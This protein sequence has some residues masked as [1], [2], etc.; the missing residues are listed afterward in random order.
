AASAAASAGPRRLRGPLRLLVVAALVGAFAGALAAGIVVTF[1]D[2]ADADLPSSVETAAAPPP[3]PAGSTSDATEASA[4]AAAGTAGTSSAGGGVGGTNSADADS[5]GTAGTDDAAPT[6]DRAVHIDAKAIYDGIVASVVQIEV[7]SADNLLTSSR[8]TGFVLT[9]DG[10]I[11]TNAH[12]LTAGGTLDVAPP[13]APADP[14]DPDAEPPV[15][16]GDDV[17]ISVR[18][19]DG[20]TLEATVLGIDTSLDLAVIAVDATGLVPVKLGSSTGV[21]VGDEVMA[22]GNALG[23]GNTHTA[24]VGIVSAVERSV[25]LANT[26]LGRLIQ[27][28]AAVNPGNSGG[29]LVNAAGEVIGI[30]TAIAG[31]DYDGL[32]FAISVDRALPAIRLLAD[33]IVPTTARLG[34]R[35]IGS[36]QWEEA[37][38]N[39][40]EDNLAELDVVLGLPGAVVIEVLPD[41]AAAAAGIEAGDLIVEFDGAPIRSGGDLRDVVT[42]L[43]SGTVVDLLLVRAPDAGDGGGPAGPGTPIRRTITVTLGAVEDD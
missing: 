22:V 30:N 14:D 37:V 17:D 38:E 7:S 36:D 39:D 6:V 32:G 23:L 5:G 34:V 8:G 15:P 41:T 13:P 9:A 19:E 35:V 2:D 42:T 29:P 21:E 27:T 31:F 1:S 20:I 3:A 26:R 4:A 40:E 28:D 24:T 33:G 11:V 25:D 10:T 43:T 12:V 18:L 16:A